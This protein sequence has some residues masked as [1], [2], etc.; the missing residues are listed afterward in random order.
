MGRA[1]GFIVVLITVGI[2]AYVY[3]Q[4]METVSSGGPAL[5]TA[6][7]V[8]GVRNDLIAIANAERRYWA[9]NARYASLDELRRN[10][11]IFIPARESYTYTADVG[12]NSFTIIASYSGTDPKAPQRITVDETMSLTTK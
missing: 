11:D 9:V 6:I 1:F 4:Q 12:E 7:D 2:G 10:G 5:N 3:M 8:T